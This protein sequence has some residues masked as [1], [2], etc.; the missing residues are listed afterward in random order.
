M[1]TDASFLLKQIL[2]YGFGRVGTQVLGILLIPLYTRLLTP[3]DFGILAALNIIISLLTPFLMLGL[4]GALARYYYEY[5]TEDD[6][7]ALIR[8]LV[9]SVTLIALVLIGMAFLG[10][11]TLSRLMLKSRDYS[12]YLRVALLTAFFNTVTA[13]PISLFQIRQQASYFVAVS[14]GQFILGLALN[15]FFIVIRRDGV[16]GV[17]Y[18]GLGTSIVSFVAIYPALL[19]QVG[20]GVSWAKLRRSLAY[21]IFLVPDSI[22]S[23]VSHMSDRWFLERFTSLT[24]LGLYSVGTRFPQAQQDLINTPTTQALSPYLYSVMKREDCKQIHTRL[25]TYILILSLLP[26][27]LVS[28]NADNLL[29]LFTTPS[30]Y[31]ASTV[32]PI[33]ALAFVFASMN[34]MLGWGITYAE[35]TR[36]YAL[37]TTSA[38]FFSLVGNVLIIPR[39]GMMGAATMTLLT[40]LFMCAF[41]YS[42]SQHVYPLRYESHHLGILFAVGGGLYVVGRL[43]HVE[44]LAANIVLQTFIGLSFF[45]LL[46]LCGIVKQQELQICREI[47]SRLREKRL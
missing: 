30:Y 31:R 37:I 12:G 3:A 39:F 4:Q 18:A 22:A 7:S 45:P 33:V 35:K 47:I 11:G 46:I 10:A 38:A 1:N 27:L 19:W 8:S 20:F 25:M 34:W 2:T 14:L 15:I 23:W 36:L 32:I 6:R 24:E 44:S 16:I 26:G 9:I 21:G 43:L 28:L 5:D 41:T 42:I 13:L 40:Y 17:L 29:R